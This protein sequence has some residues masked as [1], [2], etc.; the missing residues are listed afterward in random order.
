L[1]KYKIPAY[2]D[3]VERLPRTGSGKVQKSGLRNLPLPTE[4]SPR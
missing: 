2:V 4:L 1:A 3:L